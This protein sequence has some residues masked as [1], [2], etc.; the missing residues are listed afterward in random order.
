MKILIGLVVLSFAL[1]AG[2]ARGEPNISRQLGDDIRYDITQLPSLGGASSA[3]FSINDRGWVAGRS[4]LPDNQIRHATLWRNGVAHR[5]RHARR[6][7]GTASCAGRSRTCAASSPASRRRTSRTR[8]TRIGAARHSSPR[9][10]GTGYQCL[11][12]RW[13][14]GEMTPLPTLGGTHGFAA[15]ANNAGRIVGWAEN[16]VHDPKCVAPQVL[17]F[18]PVVWGPNDRDPGAPAASGRLLRSGH[19]D[20][21][22]RP[23][24]R[25]QRHLRPGGREVHREACRS[26]GQGRGDRHRQ[27]RRSGLAHA[28]RH[29]HP[30]RRRRILQ[31][32]RGRRRRVPPARFPLDEEDGIRDLGTLP[33]PLDD[34]SDAWGINDGA[35][36]WAGPATSTATATP[37]C[38]RTA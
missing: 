12:F 20:Q 31:L 35:R 5:S 17:Q 25:Y 6:P 36:R 37:S 13:Q 33:A 29:Q 14:N 15:G 11:G 32:L 22:P 4:N 28:K 23:D 7:E 8:T 30:R 2:A 16:T 9:A 24:R 1:L 34:N 38:G 21:R 27:P 18:L 26:L 3:G 10:T 19:G